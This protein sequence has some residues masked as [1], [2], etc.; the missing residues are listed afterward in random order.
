[1]NV[2]DANILKELTEALQWLRLTAKNTEVAWEYFTARDGDDTLLNQVEPQTNFRGLPRENVIYACNG[3]VRYETRSGVKI[4]DRVLK[5]LWA[6]GGIAVCEMVGKTYFNRIAEGDTAAFRAS[7]LGNVRAAAMEATGLFGGP[8]VTRGSLSWLCELARNHPEDLLAAQE[9]CQ[10]PESHGAALIAALLLRLAPERVNVEVQKHLLHRCSLSAVPRILFG[11]PGKDIQMLADY[12]A[13]GDLT[14]PVPVP[15]SIRLPAVDVTSAQNATWLERSLLRH[16][17]MTALLTAAEEEKMRCLLRVI[18]MLYPRQVFYDAAQYLEPEV[19]EQVLPILR[20]DTPGGGI[21]LALFFANS[22]NWKGAGKAVFLKHCREDMVKALQG[23]DPEQYLSLLDEGMEPLPAGDVREKLA[24]WFG[25]GIMGENADVIRAFV[26]ADHDLSDSAIRLAGIQPVRGHIRNGCMRLLNRYMQTEGM[27][28]FS[29]RCV[30]L[31]GMLWSDPGY[32]VLCWLP[33]GE[34]NTEQ[35][36]QIIQRLCGLGLPVTEV[37]KICGKVYEETYWDALKTAVRKA[38]LSVAEQGTVSDFAGVLKNGSIFL[39]GIALECLDARSGESGAKEAILSAIAD[40]SKQI[41][42]QVARLLPKHPEWTEDYKLLLTAKKAAVRQMAAETLGRLGEKE[43]LEAAL[44]N[45]KNAKVAD[46]IRAALGSETAAPVGSAAELAAELTK[47]N[48]LKKL[49]W[50]LNEQLQTVRN[51]DGTPADDSIRNAVLLSYSEL[52]RIGRSDTAAELAKNLDAG[53]LEKLA[54]QVYDLW[55]AAGAQAKQKWVLPFAAVYGGAAMTQR[56]H[57]AIHDWPEHQRGAIACDAV[58][59]LALST[60]PAAIVIVDSLSRKF[61]F[62]QI[63]AAAAAALENAAKE[64]GISAE[65]LA[66]RIVPD[67]GFGR[68]GKQIFDY[69]KRSFTVRLTST[70]EL[71]ITNDQGKTVKSMPAPGKTDDPQ[72]IEAYESFKA[73]KKGI[74]TTVTAQR[75]RLESALSVLRCWDTNRW[76]ALFV[77][78]PIMH[79]FAMSLIWGIYEDG[80]LTDTF[81]Y[82]EDGSFNTVDEDEYTLPEYAKIGLVHPVELD[83]DTLEGWKQ[84]LEDYEIKQSIDQ[85][86]R[87]VHVLDKAKAGEKA[88]EDFGGKMLNALSLSGKLLQQG[89]YRGSVV[90]GGGFFCFYRE[91]KELGIGVELRFSGAAVGYDEGEDVTVFDAVFYTGTINRGSYVYDTIPEGRIVPL[92]YVPARFYSEIVHQLTRATAS[93]TRS[94]ENWRAEKEA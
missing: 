52:G 67:L 13:A 31:A 24:R 30:A 77:D 26:M 93:S 42:E 19:F 57:K 59:A 89:W 84:Q 4:L 44:A 82:M 22:G 64:L 15:P 63:K 45:E 78:N 76:Q 29:I 75:A 3:F 66:D 70:L 34:V 38:A 33:G 62:R 48:K 6:A 47:G 1:M 25:A 18:L 83:A 60:D 39:R 87:T 68:D 11:Q 43:A 12:V 94:N 80:K 90:D 92:G 54:V 85:L 65:E 74:K 50:L 73:M 58:M 41:R 71:E 27:D 61:R 5:F 14:V 40:S 16:Y 81:R 51:A 46:A 10:D 7:T 17:G 35:L 56:L 55:F 36:M 21:S 32:H 23:A 53:D 28:D 88:L 9:L 69:G 2:Q 37:F 79:Q 8:N 86:G 20:A 49:G 72:A 91:D